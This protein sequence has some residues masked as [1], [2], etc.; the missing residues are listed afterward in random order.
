MLE[1]AAE[2]S[3]EELIRAGELDHDSAFQSCVTCW[4]SIGAGANSAVGKDV[5]KTYLWELVPMNNLDEVHAAW[6]QTGTENGD[7][8][9]TIDNATFQKQLSLPFTVPILA[10]IWQILAHVVNHGLSIGANL[11]R[12]FT[13]AGTRPAIWTCCNGCGGL[14]YWAHC[15]SRDCRSCF[16]ADGAVVARV[17]FEHAKPP[18]P[19]KKAGDWITP[20]LFD[21]LTGLLVRS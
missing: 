4:M 20:L 1:T 10:P 12:F 14:Y 21:C 3:N 18:Q 11:R 15:R 8:V 16:C 9:Q 2:L 13:S 5:G 19:N 6:A 7:Y 17:F